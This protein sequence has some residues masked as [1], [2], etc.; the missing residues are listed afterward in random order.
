MAMLHLGT[1]R[2]HF[3]GHLSLRTSTGRKTVLRNQIPIHQPLPNQPDNQ[4][5][6]LSQR[7]RVPSVVLPHESLDIAIQMLR[8]DLVK[9]ALVRPFQ[10]APKR[11]YSISVNVIPDVLGNGMLDCLTVSW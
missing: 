5:S 6:H 10:R 2:G 1:W 7:I 8:T 4:K 9:H 3:V 11:L